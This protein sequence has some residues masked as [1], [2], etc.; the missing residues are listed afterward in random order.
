[1]FILPL[2]LGLYG[3]KCIHYIVVQVTPVKQL[4][5]LIPRNNFLSLLLPQSSYIRQSLEGSLLSNILPTNST[6]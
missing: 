1:M 2:L 5:V 4:Q 6:K 3:I